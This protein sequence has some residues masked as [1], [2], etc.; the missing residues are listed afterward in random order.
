M[1]KKIPPD[2]AEMFPID[3]D[4][5]DAILMEMSRPDSAALPPRMHAGIS[6][7]APGPD[8][9]LMICGSIRPKNGMFPTAAIAPPVRRATRKNS[10]QRTVSTSTPR[11][12]ASSSPRVR[13]LISREYI[14]QPV[15]PMIV[16]GSC[17]A[18]CC[19][20]RSVVVPA[21]HSV[22]V[23]ISC[24]RSLRAYRTL[25]CIAVITVDIAMPVSISV[26]LVLVVR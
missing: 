26:V 7:L 3:M 5:I 18:T 20:P 4:V 1:R 23:C 15:N 12:L 11:F 6:F 10:R 21:S 24:H 19:H 14:R 25:P 17:M 22:I 8:S 9:V 16:S 2:S 13:M